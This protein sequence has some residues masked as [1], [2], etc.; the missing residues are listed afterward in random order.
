MCLRLSWHT[1][2]ERCYFSSILMR[3]ILR[4]K[5]GIRGLRCR[6]VKIMRFCDSV[7]TEGARHTVHVHVSEWVGGCM[8]LLKK[9]SL[10]RGE[11][12]V[13]FVL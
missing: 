2:A 12:R 5:T 9:L 4:R 3:G 13:E 1:E 10:S 7:V 6:M 8:S 11:F